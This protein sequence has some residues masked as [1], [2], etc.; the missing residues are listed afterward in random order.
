[1][2]VL[3]VVRL[4]CSSSLAFFIM[5]HLVGLLR[6]FLTPLSYLRWRRSF[7]SYFKIT[8]FFGGFRSNP[9]MVDIYAKNMDERRRNFMFERTLSSLLV[10]AIIQNTNTNFLSV[11]SKIGN[12]SQHVLRIFFIH[13]LEKKKKLF[14]QGLKISFLEL[15]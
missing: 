1:M 2:F 9:H 6:Q 8:W 4:C 5:A 7:C 14:T 11:W 3:I 15:S 12:S 10:C 13:V